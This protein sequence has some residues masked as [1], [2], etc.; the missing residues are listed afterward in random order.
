MRYLRIIAWRFH[1]RREQFQLLLFA[2]LVEDFNRFQP[3]G[4][5]GTVQLPEIA[6]RFLP[7]TIRCAYRFHQRPV[8]MILTGLPSL[9]RT[10]KHSCPMLSWHGA[11]FKRVGLHYIDFSES[12]AAGKALTIGKHRKIIQNGPNVTNFA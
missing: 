5:R 6:Q 8:S 10:Q 7:R 3:P 2:L 9:V 11:P 4:L 12:F 1:L